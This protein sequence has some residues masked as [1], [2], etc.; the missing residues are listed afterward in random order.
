MITVCIP[1]YR[2]SAFIGDTLASVLAQ[3]FQ[4][5]RVE[6]AIDPTADDP[7]A[8]DP[9]SDDID[10]TEAAL[11]LFRDDS[12]VQI[13]VNPK[14][15]GWAANFNALLERVDT[16]FFVPL[17]HD[18][19]WHPDYLATFYPL[20]C[21]NPAAAVAYGDM[22]IFGAE[23]SSGFRAVTLPQGEDRMTH[24]IRFML[25]GAHAMPWRGLT[26]RSATAVTGGFPTD[27]WSGFAV[28]VEYALGLLEAGPVIHVPR[29]L[30]RKRVFTAKERISA[31]SARIRDWSVKERMKAW[32]RH[33]NALRV[34]MDRMISVYDA[35]AE[36]SLLADASFKAAMVLRRQNMVVPGLDQAEVVAFAALHSKVLRIDHPLAWSVAQQLEPL[37]RQA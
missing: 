24:L 16:P 20:M 9:G 29:T 4:D 35:S 22:T 17:P 37:T 18:D 33:A 27:Q 5:F 19:L 8:D 2:A 28:E 7:A 3:S 13:V 14:R 30:Y 26:R 10:D 1:A 6:I 34:R 31:S 23:N 25:Q 32:K 36:A 21:D 12:R 11:E 15:L